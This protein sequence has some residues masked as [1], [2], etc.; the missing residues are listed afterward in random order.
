[1]RPS[2]SKEAADRVVERRRGVALADHCGEVEGLSIAQ[3]A[4]RLGRS[5]ATVEAYFY[6]ATGE[7]ARAVKAL[8]QG[9]CRGCGAY[10]QSRKGKGDA[11][12]YC[13]RCHPGR[14]RAALDPPSWCSRRCSRGSSATDVRRRPTTGRGRTRAGAGVSM[15]SGA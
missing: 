2:V 12:A 6:D 7:R 3:I 4:E 9:V 5:P 1:M 13:K 10:T 11:Y 15:A 8:Y 14:D